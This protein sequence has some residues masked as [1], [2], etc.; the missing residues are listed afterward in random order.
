MLVHAAVDRKIALDLQKVVKLTEE[1]K[2]IYCNPVDELLD[3]SYFF[4]GLFSSTAI[5]RIF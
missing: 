5:I 2:G 4:F 3:N 1:E